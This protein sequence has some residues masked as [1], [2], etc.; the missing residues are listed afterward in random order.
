[1]ETHS[2]TATD[3]DAIRT[4]TSVTV[5]LNKTGQ[6]GWEEAPLSAQIEIY[7]P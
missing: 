1:M 4:S 3:S 5:L 7:T 2:H 6:L